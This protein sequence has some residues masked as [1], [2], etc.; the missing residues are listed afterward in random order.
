MTLQAL[1]LVE[2]RSW[3]KFASHYTRGTNGV[4]EWQDGCIV[5]MDYYM[6]SN[7]SYFMVTWIIL[8]NHILKIGLTQKRDTMALQTLTTV[9]LVYFMCEDPRE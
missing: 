1:S 8:K 4:R 5:Y 3:S 9:D 6:A 7:G 2:R